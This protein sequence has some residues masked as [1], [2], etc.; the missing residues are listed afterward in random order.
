MGSGYNYCLF[1]RKFF[2]RGVGSGSV[3]GGVVVG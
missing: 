2:R 3:M 1:L